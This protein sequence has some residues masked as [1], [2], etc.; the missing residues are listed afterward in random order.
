MPTV[1]TLGDT[2]PSSGSYDT[3]EKVNSVTGHV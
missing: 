1:T 3:S 2:W